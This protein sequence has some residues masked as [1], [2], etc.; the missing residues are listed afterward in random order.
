MNATL[1]IHNQPHT[2]FPHVYFR[3][4]LKPEHSS[5]G[6]F[7]FLKGPHFWGVE[8]THSQTQSLRITSIILFLK[9]YFIFSYSTLARAFNEMLLYAKNIK[10]WTT[11]ALPLGFAL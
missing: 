11:C 3:L 5:R 2:I 9:S 4:L 8:N 6:F 10:K 7:I 1:K